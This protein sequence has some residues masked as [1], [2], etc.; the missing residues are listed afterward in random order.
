MYV[1]VG[2]G[3]SNEIYK[4]LSKQLQHMVPQEALSFLVGRGGQRAQRESAAVVSV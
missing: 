3:N 2:A 1:T 4:L